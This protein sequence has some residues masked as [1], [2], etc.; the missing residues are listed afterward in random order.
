[1]IG[2][3][4][5]FLTGSRGIAEEFRLAY[6]ARLD[7]QNDSERIAAEVNIAL[8]N[9]KLESH[10]IGGRWITLIQILWALPFVAYNSKLVIYD[11]MLGLGVTDPLSPE[12][13]KLQAVIVGFF[14][15]T[16]TVRAVAGR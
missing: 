2:K 9:A 4:I 11:K 15:V 14:F 12:L 10:R 8:L 1:M 16:S 6:Q 13:Y 5:S 7:A 3:I